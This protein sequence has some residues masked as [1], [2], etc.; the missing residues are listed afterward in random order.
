M[1]RINIISKSEKEIVF[2]SVE[3]LSKF[4]EEV[5]NGKTVILVRSSEGETEG[6]L[7][8]PNNAPQINDGQIVLRSLQKTKRS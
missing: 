1:E 7:L 8:N 5:S 6:I 3:D 4:W 2:N